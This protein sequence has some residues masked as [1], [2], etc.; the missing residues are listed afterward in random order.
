[1]RARPPD[2]CIV[3]TRGTK[4]YGLPLFGTHYG[5]RIMAWVNQNYVTAETWGVAPLH[6]DR[7]NDSLPG[8]LALQRR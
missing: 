6:P 3:L 8:M 5:K 4:E 7:M 1:M 2:Y